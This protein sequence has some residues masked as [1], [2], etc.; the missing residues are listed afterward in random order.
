MYMNTVGV[1]AFRSRLGGIL[2]RVLGG[3]SWV[4]TSHDRPV[5]RLTPFAE[6]DGF[7]VTPPT[8]PLGAWRRIRGLRP[9]RPVN[10]VA[11]L[12]EERTRR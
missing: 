3:D 10:V 12:R 1:A 7:L 9:E 6:D 2:R 4:I 5:A 8:L 11:L